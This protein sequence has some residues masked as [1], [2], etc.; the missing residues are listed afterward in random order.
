LLRR[1]V[2]RCTICTLEDLVEVW[3]LDLLYTKYFIFT[4]DTKASIYNILDTL[5]SN[6]ATKHKTNIS[7]SS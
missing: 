4:L 1:K 2:L 7:S 5:P 6:F 3:L